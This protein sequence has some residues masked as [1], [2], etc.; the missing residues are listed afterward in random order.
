MH[1]KCNT[2]VNWSK[3]CELNGDFRRGC[4]N[5]YYI[6]YVEMKNKTIKNEVNY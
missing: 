3:Q 2:C 6:F 5:Y 1:E 4:R